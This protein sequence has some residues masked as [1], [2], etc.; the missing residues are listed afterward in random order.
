MDNRRLLRTNLEFIPKHARRC[1]FRRGNKTYKCDTIHAV[2]PL[3][4]DQQSNLR[5]TARRLYPSDGRNRLRIISQSSP[6]ALYFLLDSHNFYSRQTNL[7]V[8]SF[9]SFFILVYIY[10]C[11]P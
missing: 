10:I 11:M 5:P 7:E 3:F 6:N 1:M 8:N 9:N 2:L 4:T